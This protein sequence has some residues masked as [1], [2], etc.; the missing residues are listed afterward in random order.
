MGRDGE[1]VFVSEELLE[2]IIES[3]KAKFSMQ[4]VV[5]GRGGDDVLGGDQ[6]AAASALLM[7][8]TE[9]FRILKWERRQRQGRELT[10]KAL[11]QRVKFGIGT[12][13]VGGLQICILF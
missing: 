5:F 9:Q 2:K 1:D 10:R 3:L 13:D 4:H 11:I 6:V 12:E 8:G 7:K